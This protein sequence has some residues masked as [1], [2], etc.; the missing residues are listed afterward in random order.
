MFKG[1]ASIC[2]AQRQ[3]S[4]S[5]EFWSG[6]TVHGAFECLQAIDLAFSLTVVPRKFNGI[7][8][9][10]DVAVQRAGKA[11]DWWDA[12]LNGQVDPCVQR[13]G[14]VAA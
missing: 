3:H 13:G 1:S 11:H 6:A 2:V 9:G 10:L 4:G 8:H 14:L 5:E 7:A 12:S